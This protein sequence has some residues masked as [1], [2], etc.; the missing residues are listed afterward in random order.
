ME[1]VVKEPQ[2]PYT[3]LL[4]ASIPL[5]GVE[6]TWTADGAPAP[7]SSRPAA[8]APGLPLRGPLPLGHAGVPGRGAAAVPDRPVAA[9]CPASC[10]GTRPWCRRAR[11]ARR[12]SR[13][14][15][16]PA[17]RP[18]RRPPAR[19]GDALMARA[20][21]VLVTGSAGR[22][23]RAV[24]GRAPRARP[25][26]AGLR[27]RPVPRPPGRRSRATSTRPADLARAMAGAETLVHLAATPDE[28][29]FL[30]R[31]PA[32]QRR[33]PLPCARGGAP[34]QRHGASSSRAPASSSAAIRDRSRSRPRRR[35]R[36]AT[37][38]LPPRCSLEAA[39]HVYAHVHGLDVLVIRCG[40]CPRD[41]AH[42]AELAAEPVRAGQLPEPGRRR[43]LL[44][45]RR[46]SRSPRR[47]SRWSTPPAGPSDHHAT[48]SGRPGRCSATSR[49]D[50]WPEGLDLAG[51]G[52]AT[53]EHRAV[54]EMSAGRAVDRAP[55]GRGGAARLRDRRL[56]L[57]RRAGRPP[58]RQER[59]VRE[60]P[61]RAGRRLHGRRSRAGHR[62]A[63]RVPGDERTRRDEPRHRHRGGPRGALARRGD[64]R[65]LRARARRAGRLPGARPGR[66][67]PAGDEAVDPG[68]PGRPG[69]R[70]CSGSRFAPR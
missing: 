66:A 65:R 61:S 31:A 35:R 19:A 5:A 48:T 29:D 70:T 62:H 69:S 50:R 10:T 3:Q 47:A 43:P 27:S 68:D 58:R 23:G 22:L 1:L 28:A 42:A 39:G 56:D 55:E 37:G 21:T 20:R 15:L 36:R 53:E 7:A 12:S 46:R 63:G 64:R 9:W 25:P 57:P 6:R 24:C 67:L 40:W 4:V 54:T 17:A 34:E 32:E 38:T 51:A 41:P 44:R 45:R 33:G 14:W 59:G 2:H 30:T 52:G 49:R 26:G 60:R 16:R 11:W 13:P 18:P 8:G